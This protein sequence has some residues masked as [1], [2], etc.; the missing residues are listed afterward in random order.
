[1]ASDI[2]KLS[3]AL[4]SVTR[5]ASGMAAALGGSV[6]QVESLVSRADAIRLEEVDTRHLRDA[7]LDAS[8]KLSAAVD[9][10]QTLRAHATGFAASLTSDRG[11]NSSQA[12]IGS[13]TLLAPPN[14]FD[15]E[16]SDRGLEL[17]DVDE[18][19]FADNPITDW[20]K[21]DGEEN[22]RWAVERWN[23]TIA[24]GI[25]S[26]ATRQDFENYDNLHGAGDWRKL[27]MVWDM[28][29]GNDPIVAGGAGPNGKLGVV[30]GRHRIQAAIAVGVRFLPVRR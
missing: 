14:P 1:M 28:F 13:S 4:L 5:D 9:Q 30:G 7:L 17:V 21:S 24:P 19:D 27:A 20:D 25:A 2:Q 29:L 6:R 22:T 8:T 18:F 3:A 15:R 26:G 23:D 16:L 12:S 10:M 11:S